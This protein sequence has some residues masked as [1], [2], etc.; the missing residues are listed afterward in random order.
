MNR[1]ARFGPEQ[2]GVLA[3]LHGHCFASPWQASE[4]EI[5]LRQPGIMALMAEGSECPVG[6]ILIRAVADEAEILTLAVEPE[7]RRQGVAS[8]LLEAASTHLQAGSIARWFLEGAADNAE[9]RALYARH[10][11]T[12]CGTRPNYYASSPTRAAADAVV[13][14]RPV[15]L[16]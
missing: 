6:F 9:A 1:I 3:I 13:M 14:M 4:F 15:A 7:H 5:L 11:F 16:L 12:V 2:A 10:G 8:R